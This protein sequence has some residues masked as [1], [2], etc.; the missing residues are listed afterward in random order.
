MLYQIE[1][2]RKREAKLSKIRALL[3]DA[4]SKLNQSDFY[5]DDLEMTDTKIEEAL[6]LLETV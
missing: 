4:Q 5:D 2:N 3:V 1:E 6:D